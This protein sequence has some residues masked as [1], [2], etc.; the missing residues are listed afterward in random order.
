MQDYYRGRDKRWHFVGQQSDEVV[1]KI[2]HK[3]WIFLFIPALP[4]VG[5]FIVLVILLWVSTRFSKLGLPWGIF[6][7]IDVILMVILLI[8]LG[9]RDLLEWYLETYIITN[10]RII[11]SRGVFEPTRQSTP[12]ENVK[13]VGIDLDTFLEFALRYGTVHVYL[14]GGDLIIDGIPFP[15]HV[16]DLIDILTQGIQAAKPKEAAPPV[17][18]NPALETVISELSKPKE[19]PPLENADEHYPPPR[20]TE[21]RFGPDALLEAFCI[22][23]PKFVT[24]P[25]SKLSGTFSDHATFSIAIFLYL[26]CCCSSC[27]HSPFM[28]HR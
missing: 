9:W 20:H 4:A 6:E 15:R 25:A 10:K 23:L 17:P 28:L 1:H 3:H 12:L 26:S 18:A 14:I 22:S 21:R 2:L 24:S 5:A 8:W 7:L 27:F 19:L 13:Q 16:K 11:S